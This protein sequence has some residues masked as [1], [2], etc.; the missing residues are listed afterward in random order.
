V[1][2]Q[3]RSAQLLGARLRIS[4]VPAFLLYRR[5]QPPRHLRL[6]R[7]EAAPLEAALQRL[8]PSRVP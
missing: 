2:S 5:G 6:S 4:S 3:L 7:L 1:H 8:L